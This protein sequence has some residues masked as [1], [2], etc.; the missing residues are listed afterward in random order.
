[1]AFIVPSPFSGLTLAVLAVIFIC[2]LYA[3]DY[4]NVPRIIK[5]PQVLFPV[6]FYLFMAAGIF[7][8]AYPSKI[9]SG[10]TTQIAY[11]LFPLIIGSSSIINRKLVNE[12]GRMTIISTCLFLFVAICYALYVTLGTGEAIV[13]VGEAIYSRFRSFGL[14][15]VYRN[16]HPTYVA[17]FVNISIAIQLQLCSEE[18]SKKQLIFTALIV[19]FLCICLILLNSL[20]GIVSFAM[21][22]LYHLYQLSKQLQISN[23]IKAG[24]LIAIITGLFSLYYFNPFQ[25]E[26]I[27]SLKNKAF[28]ITDNQDQ[29][30]LL[31]MRLAKW[32]THIDIFKG[33]W[34]GGTTY[35]DINFIRKKTYETKGY[36]DLAHYNYNAH[37]QYL[38][39]LATYGIIGGVIF[40]GLLFAPVFNTN[41][42]ALTMPFLLIVALTFL[43][44]SILVRQQ[45]ILYF[46]FFY[47]LYTH[48][49]LISKQNRNLLTNPK[50]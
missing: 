44:E 35:G 10:L 3:D 49:N 15:N 40:F 16:W 5:Q 38:E 36:Q 19:L 2:W 21:L 46:M 43:T 27:D 33:Y 29:R 9:L 18:Y 11:V 8:S 22:V 17:M 41:K 7:Y 34:L 26:K 48:K 45:G 37:N 1:M 30:N 13:M 4:K 25:N 14:T 31:T 32:E 50:F 39:V 47:V 28:T 24:V 12:S 20:I 23:K 42:Y 6:A